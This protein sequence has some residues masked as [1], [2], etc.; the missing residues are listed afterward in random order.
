MPIAGGCDIGS[1]G[2]HLRQLQIEAYLQGQ[3]L[4]TV[5]L[6]TILDDISFPPIGETQGKASFLDALCRY[7]SSPA[8]HSIGLH[9]PTDY[10][11]WL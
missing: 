9:L 5:Q 1:I 8:A 7:G 6:M 2:I 4:I 11:R 10:V 3:K